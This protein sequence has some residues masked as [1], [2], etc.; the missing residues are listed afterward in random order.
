MLEEFTDK[1]QT[2]L[3]QYDHLMGPLRR[4]DVASNINDA[5]AMLAQHSQLRESINTTAVESLTQ[6]AHAIMNRLN[7]ARAL[8]S[9]TAGR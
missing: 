2:L 5:R 7:Q 6:D 9:N 3:I 4:K 1:T 8:N